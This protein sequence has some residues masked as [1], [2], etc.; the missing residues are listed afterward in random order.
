[1]R[2]AEDVRVGVVLQALAHARLCESDVRDASQ[3][4]APPRVHPA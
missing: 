3:V 4:S 1:M 2:G